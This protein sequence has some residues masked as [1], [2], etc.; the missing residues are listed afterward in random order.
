MKLIVTTAFGLEAVTARE[1]R[2][3]GYED[4]VT[5]N[6]RLLLQGNFSFEDILRLNLHL[7]TAGR[8]LLEVGSFVAHTYDDLFEGVRAIEWQEYLPRDA[9]FPVA[10][11]NINS[12]LMSVPDT[13]AITKKAVA[14]KLGECYGATRLPEGGATYQI[15][16]S[17]R[18]DGVSITLDTSGEGLHKRG[19]RRYSGGAPLRETMAAALVQ[20]S[21]WNKE[22]PLVD[23]FCGSGTILI[24][25]A[26]MALHVAPGLLREFACE[27][28]AMADAAARARVRQAAK[29]AM[30]SA[31]AQALLLRQEGGLHWVGYDI[32]KSV[33]RTARGNAQLAG[34]SEYIDFH[35]RSF[36]EFAT[37]RKYG[38]VVT[39]PPYGVRLGEIEVAEQLIRRMGETFRSLPDWSVYIL[40]S[41]RGVERLYG[42]KATRRRKL[43]NGSLQTGYYQ[44]LGDRPPKKE[45]L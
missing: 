31:K 7:R 6:G 9:S 1:V 19:Y 14:V 41:C 38:V 44:F 5:E 10:A 16:T 29:D 32:D 30:E 12:T 21:V 39:N 28:W 4:F 34:V 25:A 35:P 23:P 20:L 24:E 45:T 15:E 42:K 33:L 13:Q 37:S 26:M 8:V 40:T 2:L 43:F 27:H 3:L 18:K 36:E 11:R 22:R 17:I